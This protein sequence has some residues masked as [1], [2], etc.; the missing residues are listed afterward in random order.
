VDWGKG[1]LLAAH[2]EDRY[3]LSDYCVFQ[4]LLNQELSMTSLGFR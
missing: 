4:G 2:I 1:D 3:P